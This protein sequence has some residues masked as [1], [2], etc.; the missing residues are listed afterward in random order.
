MSRFIRVI[1]SRCLKGLLSLRYQIE[2]KSMAALFSAEYLKKGG[3]LFLPNHP[4]EVDPLILQALL[5]GT[6]R[7][8]PLVIEHFYYLKGAHLFMK[9][10]D[11]LP[12]PNFEMATNTWK[13]RQVEKALE[14][15]KKAVDQ[16]DN[17]LIY[18]SGHLKTDGSEIVGG[19]S[20][21][22]RLLE[23]C[24]NIKIVLVRTTGLWG[25]SFSRAATGRSPDFWK[26]LLHGCRVL[27]K[28]GFFFVPK[29]K[30]T[31]EFSLAPTDF[32]YKGSRIDV[33]QYLENW[34]N[35][36]TNDTGYITDKEPLKL[37]SFSCFSRELLPIKER[38]KKEKQKSVT[39]VPNNIR[40]AVCKELARLSD[41]ALE[42]IH[43]E[44]DL[45]R[46]L[47]LDSLDY[48]NIQIFL[49]EQYDIESIVPEKIRTVSDL[50]ELI[51]KG[52]IENQSFGIIDPKTYWWPEEKFRPAVHYPKGENIQEVFL[53]TCYRM[54]KNFA[55]GDEFT[56]FLTY[57]KLKLGVITL[58]RKLEVMPDQY[59]GVLLPS[60]V[61]T[62]L[63]ILAI[64]MAGK[65]PVILNWTTGARNLNFADRLLHLQTIFSSR[66]FL[67]RADNVEL[68][69]LEDKVILMES[70]RKK[71]SF[72]DKVAGF[73]LSQ[74]SQP[75]LMK[76]FQIK[77]FK[78]QD[79]AVI[80]FTSGTETY[81]K[82]VPLSHQNLITNQKA[83]LSVVKINR[84]DVLLGVLPPFHSFGFS[85]TGLLPLL[86]GLRV[87]FSPDPTDSH[88]MARDCYLRNITLLCCAPSF[89]RNLFRI[90]TS[91]QL[92][93]IRMFVTGAEKAPKQLF[94]SVKKLEGER[95]LIEGYGITECSPIVTLCRPGNPAKGVGQP[96][97]GVELCVIHPE[98]GKKLSDQEQG[99]ICVK[100]PNVFQ[101][102]MGE[103][104]PNPFIELEGK[105]WYRSGD[106][107][108]LDK[109]GSLIYGGRIKRFVKIGGEMI[110]L[111]ALEEELFHLA[112]ERNWIP[113]DEDVPQ[114]AIG[115]VEKEADKP[116]LVLFTTFEIS[117]QEINMVLRSSGFGRIVKI[118]AVKQ[119]PEI[120]MTGT[121]KVHFH[122]INE[123]LKEM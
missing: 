43:D 56:K 86:S 25:S 4:A 7:I 82:A 8:R 9:W 120:P 104:V 28:N 46:D 1:L 89:Y 109:D 50:F 16:G 17:F 54:R 27:L 69:V 74:K 29:R 77:R 52:E 94:D 48:A 20:F 36:Y 119:I 121:G 31:V 22:H 55:C 59:L 95:V 18:P 35:Q 5:M 40:M 114:L 78:P 81:P 97:P 53:N 44:M 57:H 39:E 91:Q 10:V 3:I 88:A 99:E 42:D 49:D 103:Q 65:T 45:A 80:L 100:G 64:L 115:V 13:I 87:F 75:S 96:L 108:S 62:F 51:I 23:I 116:L 98:T 93:S 60:S 105:K 79:P 32:P 101:G 37:V 33:N 47:G 58:A 118:Q 11:A 30:V 110:S 112:K 66:R 6:F 122:C 12:L 72:W 38:K 71:L 106:L 113:K 14:Q 41:L 90:A 26:T 24:P 76:R 21:V 68:G 15:V 70:F 61:G 107:G 63:L 84:D 102:Y 34:Y 123:M 73:C 83:A 2:V 117:P 67:E 85:V 19:N 111:A 92:Q